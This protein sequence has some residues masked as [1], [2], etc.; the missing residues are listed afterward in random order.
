LTNEGEPEGKST[1]AKAIERE[2]KEKCWIFLTSEG[3]PEE[4]HKCQRDRKRIERE[5]LDILNK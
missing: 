5:M 4:N 2:S 3:E 1:V